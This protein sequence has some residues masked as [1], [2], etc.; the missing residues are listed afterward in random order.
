M[1][2]KLSLILARAVL[3]SLAL[4]RSAAQ[5]GSDTELQAILYLSACEPQATRINESWWRE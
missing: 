2:E 1:P 3:F 5:G 4:L